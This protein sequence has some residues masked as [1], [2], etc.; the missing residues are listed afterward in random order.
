MASP[1]F[2]TLEEANA[3]L[4]QLEDLIGEILAVRQRILDHQSELWPVLEKAG[5][6]GGNAFASAIVFDFEKVRQN[7]QAIQALG[8]T[9]KDV[10][11][12]LVDFLS[13][14]DGREIYLCWRYGE[15]QISYWHELHTGFA[16]RQPI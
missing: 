12:G 2:F 3:L 13:Y 7:V 16:G 15:P 9:L 10:N 14:R 4:P 8:V 5:Q 11:T 1:R 6:N